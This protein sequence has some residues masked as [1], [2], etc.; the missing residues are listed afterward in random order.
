MGVFDE[1]ERRRTKGRQAHSRP[2]WPLSA[3]ILVGALFALNILLAVFLARTEFERSGAHVI[4][5]PLNPQRSKAGSTPQLSAPPHQGS[6]LH[7]ESS[8]GL[9]TP[10][11]D[12][13]SSALPSTQVADRPPLNA[14]PKAFRAS[15]SSRDVWP[16]PRP[17]AVIY[18]P[19]QPFVRIPAPAP[20]PAA[21]SSASAVI[22]PRGR[23]ASLGIPGAGVPSNGGPH[24][25]PPAASALDPSAIGHGL[26]AKGIRSAPVATVASVRLPAMETG[27][28]TPKRAV[29]P[30]GVKVEM[31]PR[32]PVK[33]ENCGDEEVFV[34]CPKL[35]IRYDTPYTTEVP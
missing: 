6:S 24:P 2:S 28:M 31:I 15:K 1:P 9:N 34:A 10:P 29:A 26:T 20:N 23:A 21:S 3:R 25:K 18:P 35:K 17:R 7:Q 27:L 4:Y 8:R 22:P 33:L 19:H 14:L 13:R 32:P 30:A 5:T 12:A 11:V 16:A